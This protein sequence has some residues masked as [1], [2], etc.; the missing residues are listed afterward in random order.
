MTT[1]RKVIF[2]LA[3]LLVGRMML[4][5]TSCKHDDQDLDDL[6]AGGGAK[7]SETELVS[8]RTN[9]PPSLDGVIDAMWENAVPL[10]TRTT[11]PNIG[12]EKVPANFYGYEGRSYNVSL[13]SMYDS[14]NIYF[15]VEWDDNTLS[16]DRETWYFD[17]A[18]KTWKQE[19]RYP[20][21]NNDGVIIR[22][23]FYEDKFA[24]LWNIDNS[25]A[26]W[27]TKTC[28][29]SC[30]TGLGQAAGYSRH[31]TNSP[32]E[33]IDMWHWKLVREGAFGTVDDQYQ[34]NA[35][36]NGRKSDPKTEGTGYSDNK[37]TLAIT[38][39]TTNVTVPKYV[40][41]GKKYYYWISRDEINNG[42]AKLVTAVDNQGVLTYNGGTIDPNV[43][44]DF[45]RA[46][47]RSGSK[48]IPSIVASR[49]MG[50]GGDISAAWKH[51]GAGYIMEI[52]RKLKTEDTQKVDVDFSSLA[53]QYFGIGVFENA[54]LA[55]AIKANLLLKFK[56]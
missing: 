9:T 32:N 10:K 50:N 25:V 7:F 4:D 18:S 17:P 54:A 5:L 39:T 3:F 15:L 41:P 24:F 52:K 37:Q 19:S 42:T 47:I 46:G 20:V 43:E 55:H 56:K 33:R 16:L 27:N 35:Q 36:P 14:E 44:T 49:T 8:I 29:A 23:A 11:I 28:Y 51:N 2:L 34:D 26:N 12:G 21:F 6:V 45:Q 48:G 31:F 53:D 1:K 40:V 38:G 13:K 22:E 30:H